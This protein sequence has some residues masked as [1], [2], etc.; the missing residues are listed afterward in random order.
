M[1]RKVDQDIRNPLATNGGDAWARFGELWRAQATAVREKFGP[2]I[3]GILLQPEAATDLPTIQVLRE[4]VS[5]LLAFMKSDPGFQY[6]FLAD[7]TATDEQ[8][9]VPRFD[10]VYHLFSHAK[11]CRIRVKT[12]VGEE[13]SVRTISDLWEG[14]N[15]AER[16]CFDMFGIRFAGHPDLRRT[17]M[18]ERFVGHPLRKD[19]PLRGYQVFPEP[20]KIHT[21]LLE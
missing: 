14:A 17:L 21:E 18:D 3:T 9:R 12:Q 10:V 1:S 5:E 7:L 20:E 8:P 6:G 13:E 16:E 15:W 11:L 4:A 2:R 19:F